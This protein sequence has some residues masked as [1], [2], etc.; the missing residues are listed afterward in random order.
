MNDV[1]FV[2]EGLNPEG[3][4][5]VL[6]DRLGREGDHLVHRDAVVREL[7]EHGITRYSK[8]RLKKVVTTIEVIGEDIRV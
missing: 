5:H 4:W 1:Y 6:S 7:R 2:I 8:V 3:E